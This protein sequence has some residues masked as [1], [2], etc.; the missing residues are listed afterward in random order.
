MTDFEKICDIENL[1]KAHRLVSN[2]KRGK[3]GY[4]N[5][6]RDLALNLAAL[7]DDLRAGTYAISGYTF[8]Q[9]KEPKTRDIYE[10]LYVDKIVMTVLCEEVLKPRLSPHFIYDNVACQ[11]GKGTHFGMNRFSQFLLAHFK[12]F[13]S[14]GYVLKCDIAG[15]F[16]NIRQ[17]V[18]KEQLARRI[19]DA[20][21]MRLLC[22]FIDSY[23]T[24][25][26][27]GIGLP[28]GNQTSQ[29]FALYYLSGI[30]HFIK[31][32][33]GIKGYVR[34]MD[35]FVLLHHDKKYLWECLG[36]ITEQT[37]ALGLLINPK[38]DIFPIGKGVEFLGWRFYVTATGGIVKRMKKQSKMRLRKGLAV[39]SRQYFNSERDLASV[40]QTVASY[41][42]HIQHGH[43]YYF[44]QRQL[45]G[46]LNGN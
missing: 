26:R 6:E 16:A 44:W 42:G 17:V 37:N 9:V 25:G 13:G 23:H 29:W 12:R 39:T 21:V 1:L 2:G 30:D 11:T 27:P 4:L 31:E 14:K 34:Y 20:D 32:Q 46:Y 38:T 41:Q 35:D 36:R 40:L 18:L 7:S 19:K 43:A 33:L 5:F 45:K 10:V 3:I 28:L 22:H 8:F 24:P 15:Y